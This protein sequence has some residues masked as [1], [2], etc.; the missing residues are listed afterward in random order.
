M[1][2]NRLLQAVR[3]CSD[4][5][6]ARRPWMAS[7]RWSPSHFWHAHLISTFQSTASPF[8]SDSHKSFS[9]PTVFAI[10]I[11]FPSSQFRVGLSLRHP[12]LWSQVQLTSSIPCNHDIG[13]LS[14]S[15][16]ATTNFWSHPPFRRDNYHS[17]YLRQSLYCTRELAP[18][19]PSCRLCKQLSNSVSS[20]DANRRLP[21]EISHPHSPSPHPAFQL[22][23]RVTHRSEWH[24]PPERQ[25]NLRRRLYSAWRL[26]PARPPVLAE[27]MDFTTIQMNLNQ[28][29]W[30]SIPHPV[31]LICMADVMIIN[32]PISRPTLV[33]CSLF[34]TLSWTRA[35]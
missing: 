22:L 30:I 21:T 7:P 5:S 26:H 33:Y 18:F 25:P 11:F 2:V 19:T 15:C 31:I 8:W 35:L 17:K 6:T 29:C 4:F 10:T 32:S 34:W 23:L 3:N 16:Q 1:S 9:L 13:I 28:F 27:E 24:Q 20:S 14:V 12:H